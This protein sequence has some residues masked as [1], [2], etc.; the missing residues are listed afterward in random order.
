MKELV[1]V[2]GLLLLGAILV[3]VFVLGDEGLQGAAS[4]FIGEG[5]DAVDDLGF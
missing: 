4:S 2:I 3:S 1:V 5:I